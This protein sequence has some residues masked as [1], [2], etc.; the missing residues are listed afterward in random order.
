[1]RGFRCN[2]V[3]TRAASRL[4]VVPL[5]ASRI[6]ALRLDRPYFLDTEAIF[7]FLLL[8]SCSNN[9]P[10]FMIAL[11]RRYLSVR[12]GI[13]LSKMVVFTGERGD[14]DNEDLLAGLQ[15]TLILKG[16]VE[17]GSENLIRSEDGFKREDV[18]PQDS[19]NIAFS[20]SFEAHAISAALEALGI[21]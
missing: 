8:K 18:V 17:F 13:E 16:S 12:W 4:N 3:Y 1:M 6:Q 19:P 14:T 7:F 9:R 21:K 5:Y 15:K 10:L 11:L 20:E 2:L